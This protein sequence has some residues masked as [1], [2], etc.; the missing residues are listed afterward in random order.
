MD[1]P[2]IEAVKSWLASSRSI[3]KKV[4][5]VAKQLE[6]LN[7]YTSEQALLVAADIVRTRL[8][9]QPHHSR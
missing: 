3:R 5:T 2:N 7:E 8:L 6:A 9:R 1:L 4:L